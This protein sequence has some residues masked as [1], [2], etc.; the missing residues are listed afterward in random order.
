MPASHATAELG[1]AS[2]RG[3][4]PE[5]STAGFAVEKARAAAPGKKPRRT[6]PRRLIHKARLT[7]MNGAH[8]PRAADYLYRSVTDSGPGAE[9]N[10]EQ[11]ARFAAPGAIIFG[12]RR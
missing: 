11:W 9:R 8:P 7:G 5:S 1:D 2:R 3:E 6:A 10:R 4:I 12:W